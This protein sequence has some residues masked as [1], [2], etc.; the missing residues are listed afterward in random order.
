MI[1]ILL[2]L[3]LGIAGYLYLNPN[4]FKRYK[5]DDVAG[6]KKSDVSVSSGGKNNSDVGKR[7]FN[8]VRRNG[9]KLDE[10][11]CESLKSSKRSRIMDDFVQIGEAS[12]YVND[13]NTSYSVLRGTHLASGMDVIIPI[14]GRASELDATLPT[15]G[16]DAIQPVYELTSRENTIRSNLSS[17]I[18]VISG[19]SFVSVPDKRNKFSGDVKNTVL[20]TLSDIT[21]FDSSGKLETCI[22][23]T[24]QENS[25]MMSSGNFETFYFS[26]LS[27]R[28]QI[29][30]SPIPDAINSATFP[31]VFSEEVKKD[32]DFSKSKSFVIVNT[33][34]EKKFEN[35]MCKKLKNSKN[36]KASKKFKNSG[37]QKDEEIQKTSKNPENKKIQKTPKKSKGFEN[38][39]ED[40]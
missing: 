32:G 8:G 34:K 21:V 16:M 23:P 38:E 24:L 14:N 29:S 9:R 15:S 22:F 19:F 2:L 5:K 25:Q 35:K 10:T 28:N 12:E 33:D 6:K 30:P 20:P 31:D 27:E 39:K 4:F 13:M 11:Q 18:S 26:D 36:Q 1:S 7:S 3:I 40:L 37:N 17:K